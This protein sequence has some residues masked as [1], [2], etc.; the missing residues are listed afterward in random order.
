ML[1]ANL[2]KIYV[3]E[4]QAEIILNLKLFFHPLTLPTLSGIQHNDI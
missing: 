4:I 1:K 2:K 3:K